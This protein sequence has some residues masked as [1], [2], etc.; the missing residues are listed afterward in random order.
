M[1]FNPDL[2]TNLLQIFLSSML[3]V[4]QEKIDMDSEYY[5]FESS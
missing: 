2:F 5:Y 1:D 4:T 3:Y